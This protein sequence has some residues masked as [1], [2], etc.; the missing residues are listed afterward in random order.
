MEIEGAMSMS[1]PDVQILIVYYSRFG[2]VRALAEQIAEG[3]RRVKGVE[4]RFLEVG[5]RP[6]EELEPG[7]SAE[8]MATRRAVLVNQLARADALVVGA[9]C[10]F[11]SMATPVKR[12]FEDCVT[13]SAALATDRS[14]PWRHHQFRNKVGAAFTASGTPHG[15]NEQTLHSI[16][17]LMMHL[18]MVLVVPGQRDPIL[19]NT[20][21]PYGATT[22]SGPD[23]DRPPTDAEADEAR[24][25]GQRVAEV[26]LWLHWGRAEW[27]RQYHVR[28]SVPAAH[29]SPFD[30]SA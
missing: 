1:T 25:L 2:A 6:V 16:L 30:P 7:E 9:P 20:A 24:A 8:E 17:T 21:A 29:V 14:R 18:G 3:A 28:T 19:E 11:G 22:I 26:A 5:D 27:Q 12:L 4:V 23:G 13:A 10:Y 15:G